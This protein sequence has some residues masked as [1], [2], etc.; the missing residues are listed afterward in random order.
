MKE[1]RKLNC[2]VHPSKPLSLISSDLEIKNKPKFV[3]FRY[4]LLIFVNNTYFLNL[5]RCKNAYFNRI[6]ICRF[7]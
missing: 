7:C 3:C 4:F 1:I 6:K 5:F 2:D